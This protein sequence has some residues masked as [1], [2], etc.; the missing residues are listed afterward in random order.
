[1]DHILLSMCFTTQSVYL[2]QHWGDLS[3]HLQKTRRT[4]DNLYH[5]YQ[6]RQQKAF[7]FFF[8]IYTSLDTPI[9][10]L[11]T[12]NILFYALKEAIAV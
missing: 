10:S 11:G 12:P 6:K 5:N 2:C 9:E 8:L 7:L 3:W 1:M 4:R